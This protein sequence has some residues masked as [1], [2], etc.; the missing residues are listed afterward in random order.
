MS[1]FATMSK[2]LLAAVAMVVAGTASAGVLTAKTNVDNA[3]TIYISTSN[4]TAGT[5]FGSGGNWPTTFTD[6]TT[7]VDGVDYY[8]HV[9][10]TDAG[11]L[12][13]FLGDFSLTGNH[14]FSN[15]QTYLTTNT[16]DWAGNNTGFNG[17]Y[18]A[19]TDL[20]ANGVSPWGTIG[21][22]G[23]SARWI[24]AGNADAENVAYFST[25]I[26]AVNSGTVPEP[27]S[28]ALLGLGVAGMAAARR[29]RKAA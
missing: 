5:A 21:A 13:G 28:L 4:S 10:G 23:G 19:L 25:K 3:Y 8:L 26:S 2:G 12:A 9:L 7:L 15:G 6:T 14:L 24:W 29:K 1:K 27:A 11:G 16:T 22:V 18:G 20:G 17:S